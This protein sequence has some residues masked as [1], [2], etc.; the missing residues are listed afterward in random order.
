M[1]Y[2]PSCKTLMD[3]FRIDRTTARKIRG[4]MRGD[5]DPATFPKTEAWI[6]QCYNMPSDTELQMSA[7]NELIDGYGVEGLGEGS[8]RERYTPPFEY[9][10]MGDTYNAT[11]IRD[12]RNGK[13]FVGCYGD[14]VERH[15]NLFK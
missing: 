1:Q 7:L 6:R 12:N 4:V 11:I 8:W 2:F 9:I 10:N 15:P 3:A 5:I 13:F 14:V